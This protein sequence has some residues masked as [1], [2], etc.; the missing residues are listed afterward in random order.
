MLAEMS[1]DGYEKLLACLADNPVRAAD[2]FAE[3]RHKLVRVLGGRDAVFPED[4]ADET[5]ARVARN[6]A[7]G[8][9]VR[10]I[11]A[12]SLRVA[13]LVWLES[14]KRPPHD[15][16][17]PAAHFSVPDNAGAKKECRAACLDQCRAELPPESDYLITEYYAAEGRELSRRRLELAERLGITREALANRAQRLRYK[18]ESCIT[19]CAEKTA[20]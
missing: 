14:L 20:I 10:D 8:E 12:Y 9:D 19:N 2:R 5:L 17:D 7:R 18:L 4:L 6:L 16:L 11:D 3:L 13:R 1:G 15:A